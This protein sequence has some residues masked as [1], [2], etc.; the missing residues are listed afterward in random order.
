MT[1]V[2]SQPA[3]ARRSDSPRRADSCNSHDPSK[4][5]NKTSFNDVK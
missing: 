5:S 4:L 3:T 2:S 1:S